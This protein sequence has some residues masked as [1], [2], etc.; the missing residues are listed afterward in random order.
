MNI[1][2]L[3]NLPSPWG[4]WGAALL[5]GMIAWDE[6]TDIDSIERAGDEQADFFKGDVYRGYFLSECAKEWLERQCP[7]CFTFTLLSCAS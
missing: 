2:Y 1:Y 6:D 3:D 5:Q 4:D 7:G